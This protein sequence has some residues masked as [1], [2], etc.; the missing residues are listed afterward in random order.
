MTRIYK[1]LP[2]NLKRLT[3]LCRGRKIKTATPEGRENERG[4]IMIISVLIL[5]ALLGISAL[6]TDLSVVY[7]EK[8]KLQNMVD[9][10]ALAGVQELP[11]SADTAYIQAVNMA[12]ANNAALN[13]VQIDNKKITVSAQKEVPLYFARIFGRSAAT[14]SAKASAVVLPA[15]SLTGV[16]PLS[17]T[18]HNFV[19]GQIYTLKNAPPD[20]MS[21][22]YGPV[23]IDGSGANVYEYNLGYGS[24]SAISIG[25]VL[26]V[27]HGN[28]SG[29]TE[30][31]LQTR[32]DSDTRIPRNTF[33]NHDRNAPE[34]VY[35]PIVEVNSGS[36][37]SVHDVIVVGF[38]AFFIE[39]VSGSGNNS[40]ITGRFLQTLVTEGRECSPSLAGDDA[41]TDYGLY[42]AK[43]V[44]N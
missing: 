9:A 21:G 38:A 8:S 39:S 3:R 6:A 23:D 16:V 33:D 19:F 29:P 20:G 7:A 27:E 42:T 31:G 28:M 32:L 13:S 35:V 5:S 15:Q 2:A 4:G 25:D 34:I 11:H 14:V 40:T 30:S 22:W 41:A 17:I 10:S 43:L 37:N 24:E 26:Q 18:L 12:Q 1:S 44:M 36:G